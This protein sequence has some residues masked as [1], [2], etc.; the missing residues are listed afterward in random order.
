[1]AHTIPPRRWF[2]FRLRTLLIA[3]AVLAVPLAW[4]AKEWRQTEYERQFAESLE[5]QGWR[6]ICGGPYDIDQHDFEN[7][8]DRWRV[9]A[10]RVLGERILDVIVPDDVD[11]VESLVRLSS[12]RSIS[13]GYWSAEASEPPPGPYTL[14]SF[15][16]SGASLCDLSAL[17]SFKSLKEVGLGHSNAG[18]LTPLAGLWRLEAIYAEN[19]PVHDISPLAGLKNLETLRL[20]STL[21]SDLSPL[22][23]LRKLKHLA[24]DQ[25]NVTD[26]TPLKGHDQLETLS[27]VGTL[28][29]KEEVQALRQALPNCVID[30]GTF[31]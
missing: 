6:C 14:D 21:V 8:Q 12:L 10:Q 25:T 11:G 4:L 28:V 22:A 19:A 27:I 17:T 5:K 3:I 1:M 23:E 18:D 26:L 24:L 30:D 15:V 16:G 9:L 31:R 29:S 13:T 20:C 2:R 7:R